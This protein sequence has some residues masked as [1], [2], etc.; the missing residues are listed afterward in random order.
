VPGSPFAAGTDPV[1]L[2]VDPSGKFVY[3]ANFKDA[4]VSIFKIDAATPGKLL[5]AGTVLTGA[6]PASIVVTK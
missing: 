4:T 6:N 1:S 5:P 2:K 3:A